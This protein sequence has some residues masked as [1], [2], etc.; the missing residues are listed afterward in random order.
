MNVKHIREASRQHGAGLRCELVRVHG[1]LLVGI[2]ARCRARATVVGGVICIAVVGATAQ[3]VG[4]HGAELGDIGKG[5]L[6]AERPFLA[7]GEVLEN[8]P[9]AGAAVDVAQGCGGHRDAAD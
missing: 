6:E 1:A 8:E 7:D 5:E 2:G 9:E 4:K 3:A